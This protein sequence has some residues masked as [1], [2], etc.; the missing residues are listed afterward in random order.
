MALGPILNDS[1]VSFKTKK[2]SFYHLTPVIHFFRPLQATRLNLYRSTA[3]WKPFHHDAAAMKAAMAK[4]QNFTVAVSFGVERDAAFEHA[5]T[6]VKH[7]A[8]K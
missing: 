8:E 1:Q 4:T 3:D 2:V 5:Q 6:K 7:A